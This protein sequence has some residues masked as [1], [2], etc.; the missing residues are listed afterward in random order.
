MR[1]ILKRR[2]HEV[3]SEVRVLI[4]GSTPEFRDLVSSLGLV[5]TV[6]DHSRENYL[7][8]GLL[9]ASKDL[10]EHFVQS[11]WLNY[12]PDEPFDIILSE[13]A[14]NVVEAQASRE[15]Y[16]RCRDFLR[17]NGR[18][19][20]KNWVRPVGYTKTLS[21]LT[22]GY[23]N[24]AGHPYGFY[25]YACVPLMLYFY[26]YKNETIDLRGFEERCRRL[27]VSGSLYESEW[28]SISVHKYENVNLR[29]YIPN[30]VD[31][32]THMEPLFSLLKSYD[33]GIAHSRYH[34]TY[35]FSR[36]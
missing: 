17:P 29:L 3:G 25:S 9:K 14:F 36:R 10:P 34:P 24:S 16:R 21:E 13:A 6:V 30:E 33:V 35:I 12:S 18:L 5:P 4:L 8:L 20:A 26:D 11:D 19:L 23:R 31:F 7:S 15:L 27:F 32:L 22:S 2:V 1:A 28:K